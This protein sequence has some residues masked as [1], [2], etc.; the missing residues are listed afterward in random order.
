[1]GE[2]EKTFAKNNSRYHLFSADDIEKLIDTNQMIT[3]SSPA[4]D[5]LYPSLNTI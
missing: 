5:N 4:V 1:M 2:G 3:T